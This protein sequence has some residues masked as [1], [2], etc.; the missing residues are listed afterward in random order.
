MKCFLPKVIHL[1]PFLYHI[2]VLVDHVESMSE[3]WF[4]YKLQQKFLCIC[5]CINVINILRIRLG[6]NT[7]MNML[8][9][10]FFIIIRVDRNITVIFMYDIRG[11]IG[12]GICI[13]ILK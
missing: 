12:M 4:E 9:T 10:S 7:V 11:R 8:T 6:N 1:H 2:H 3:N 13:I 5:N